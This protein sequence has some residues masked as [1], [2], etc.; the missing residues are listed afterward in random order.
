ML[1]VSLEDAESFTCAGIDFGMILPRD[2]TDSVEVVWESLK[3]NQHTPVDRHPTFDQIFYILKGHAEIVIGN[4]TIQVK[5]KTIVFVPRNT[6]HSVR[7]TSESGID[8]LY[9]NVWGKGVPPA[10]RGWKQVYSQIHDR[11]RSDQKEL[12]QKNAVVEPMTRT[13]STERIVDA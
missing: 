11:R 3:P 1:A 8:Y 5:P 9:F 6:D 4:E 12:K 13:E 2:L 7:P 10:E